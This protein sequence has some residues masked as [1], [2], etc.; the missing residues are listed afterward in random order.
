ML[1]GSSSPD[2]DLSSDPITSRQRAMSLLISWAGMLHP[3]PELPVVDRVLL[4]KH[5]AAAFALL[6]IAQRSNCSPTSA[7]ILPNDTML[8]LPISAALGTPLHAVVTRIH[9]ELIAPM[10]RCNIEEAEVAAMKALVLLSPGKQFTSNLLNLKIQLFSDITGLCPSTGER[11][12]EARDGLLRALFSY[13]SQM[14]SPADASVRLSNLLMLVPA[15]Y[16]I[17]QSIAEHQPQLAL[18]FGL[19]DEPPRQSSACKDALSQLS[20]T[21]KES[22]V[23]VPTSAP[24]HLFTYAQLQALQQSFPMLP[25][26]ALPVSGIFHNRKL[27]K[28]NEKV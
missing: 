10:R 13:L 2:C 9:D 7:L 24:Q 26:L 25:N 28:S 23:F 18:H 6:H 27:E 15:L 8:P 16:T 20:N 21:T 11:L 19:V 14:M 1:L 4:L 3:F 5:S 22:S 12:R 17:S